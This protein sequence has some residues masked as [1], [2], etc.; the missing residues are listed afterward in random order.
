MNKKQINFLNVLALVVVLTLAL[1][2]CAPAA[3]PTVAP[4]Q[5]QPTAPAIKESSW[6]QRPA[7]RI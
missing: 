3:T 4:T 2:A 6:L 7:L 1:A 5:A